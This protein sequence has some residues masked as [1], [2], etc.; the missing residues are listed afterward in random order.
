MNNLLAA[1]QQSTNYLP[2]TKLC[3]D[4]PHVSKRKILPTI[5]ISNDGFLALFLVDVSLR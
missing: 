1:Q 2:T 5:K 3:H 4:E